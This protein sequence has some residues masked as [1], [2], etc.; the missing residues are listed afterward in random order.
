MNKALIRT[1]RKI[2]A[3]SVGSKEKIAAAVVAGATLPPVYHNERS[4]VIE[5]DGEVVPKARPRLAMNGRTYTPE[6]TRRFE[7]AVSDAGRAVMDSRGLA[8]FSCPIITHLTIR[9]PVPDSWSPAKKA[10]APLLAPASKDLDNMEKAIFDGLNGIVYYDDVQI[11]Q[12]FSTKRYAEP[13]GKP[14][15]FSLD[16]GPSGLSAN[17]CENIEKMV[18][19]FR[20]QVTK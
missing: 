16:I 2:T 4:V 1:P 15:G 5:Y 11:V 8:P 3:L 6:S 12:K 13:G 17:D 10:L 9:L 20:K 14:A 7:K 18:K 19:V